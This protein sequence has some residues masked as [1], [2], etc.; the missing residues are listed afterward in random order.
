MSD[1][2]A[3]WH[4]FCLVMLRTG[5]LLAFWPLW[6]NRVAPPVVRVSAILAIA[7]A[8][9]PVAA[10]HLPPWPSS[11][12]EVCSLVLGEVLLGFSLGLVVRVL[13]SGAQMAGNLAALQMGFGMATLVDPQTQSQTAV[14]GELFWKLATLWFFL[15]DGHHLLLILV[16]RSFSEVP[17][18]TPFKL[19]AGLGQSLVN[20]GIW[21]FKMALTLAA[22]IVAVLFLTQVALGLVARAVPQV[23]VMLLGFPLTITL[24]LLV[25]SLT[26]TLAGSYLAAQVHGLEAPLGQ[27]MQAF[28]R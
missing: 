28:R 25:L 21:M 6:D 14:L 4:H 20:L 18:G 17:V 9:T 7:W 26:L 5:C 12:W 3:T 8:L 27:I 1:L 11:W 15:C 16:A 24:G 22:P 13:L 2:L 10:P 19:P 23:Q